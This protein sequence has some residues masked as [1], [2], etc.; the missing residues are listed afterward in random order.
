MRIK[1]PF[2]GAWQ[3]YPRR[4]LVA[5]AAFAGRIEREP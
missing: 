1:G 5:A 3:Q 2:V 4:W